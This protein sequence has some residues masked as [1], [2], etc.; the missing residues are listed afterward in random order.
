MGSCSETV[1]L[2]EQDWAFIPGPETDPPGNS[3]ELHEIVEYAPER[4][5]EVF[6]SYPGMRLVHPPEPTWWEWKA[7][8]EE[9]DRFIELEMSLFETEPVTWGGSGIRAHC[10]VQDVLKLWQAVKE[11]CPAVWLHN[12]ECAI[13]T[14]ESFERLFAH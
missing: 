7:R 10:T 13:H 5:A 11:R 2:Q 3:L 9:Q 14:P 8:W 1:E 12:S 6:L 4:I